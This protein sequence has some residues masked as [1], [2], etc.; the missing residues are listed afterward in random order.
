MTA[1][2]GASWESVAHV[3]ERE[4]VCDVDLAARLGCAPGF[5]ARVRS[6]LKMPAFPIPMP[7]TRLARPVL[8]R[9]REQFEMQ[10]IVTADGHREWLG[11]RTEDGIPLF[12]SGVTAYRVAFRLEH[13][14]E[15][16]GNVRVECVL[17]TCVEGLH[18][19]DR[20]MRERARGSS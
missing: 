19:S 20:I 8:E 11:R 16:E 7:D 3:L 14:E 15:P 9:D 17:S 13:G 1:A 10:S 18:L 4:E 12:S 6:D 2:V 5:V